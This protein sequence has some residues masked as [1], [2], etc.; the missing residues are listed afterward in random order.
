MNFKKYFFESKFPSPQKQA[1]V[2]IIVVVLIV[3][4]MVTLLVFMVEKQHLLIRR[5]SN[6]NVAEQSFQYAL[7]VNAWAERILNDDLQRD[8]DHLQEDWY[9]FGRPEQDSEEGGQDD[10]FSLGLRSQRDE[11][12]TEVTIIDIGFDGLEYSID[13]LQA[14]YNLNNLSSTNPQ[15]LRSQKQI[16]LNLLA[17]L[18]IGEEDI[19]LP[20]RLYGALIDWVDENDLE[21]ANGVESGTYGAKKTSYFAADQKLSSI[22][23]L[24]FVEGFSQEII[25]KLKPHISVLPIDNARLNINTASAELLGALNSAPVVDLESVT[26]FLAQRLQDGF[27]GFMMSDIQAAE[28]AIIGVNPVGARP[29]ENMMQVN[30]QFFQINAKVTLGDYVY[31]METVVLR[32]PIARGSSSTPK[33]SVLSREQ[34]TLCNQEENIAVED[35]DDN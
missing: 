15:Y 6:Q 32:E 3:T 34:D 8:I 11:D 19:D 7:A 26:T 28:T 25:N 22:G 23:E 14:K 20:E 24:K 16:F 1:G 13:D 18:E 12:D 5:V 9:K 33:I 35:R 31:C 29:A 21:G 4:L 17:Q 27:T 30:S 10:S 2:V